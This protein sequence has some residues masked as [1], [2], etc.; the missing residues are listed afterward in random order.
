[1]STVVVSVG[2]DHHPFD[3]LVDG[4]VAWAR[5]RADI[6]RL[7]IQH[8]S[9]RPPEI[10]EGHALLPRSRLLQ[11]YRTADIVITQV[12]PGTIA[13]VNGVGR[14]PIVVPRDPRRGEVVDDHQFAYGRFMEQAGYAWLAANTAE[15]ERLA[16]AG[17]ENPTMGKLLIAPP[18]TADTGLELTH[19]VNDVMRRPPRS[20]SFRR[21]R[22]MFRSV[23]SMPSPSTPESGDS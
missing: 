10:G 17:L 20:I 4:V 13:D 6:T 11:L 9:S 14:R 5:A 19:A 16:N 1:M 7:I 2:T 18:N 22:H 3:R 8:G 21:V 12:G 15:L 23:P